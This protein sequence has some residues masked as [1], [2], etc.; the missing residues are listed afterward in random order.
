MENAFKTTLKTKL[1]PQDVFNVRYELYKLSEAQKFELQ[2]KFPS[3]HISHMYRVIGGIETPGV[4]IVMRL[5]EF[6]GRP[7]GNYQDLKIDY[8]HPG[9]LSDEN[10][11]EFYEKIRELPKHQKLFSHSYLNNL[12]TGVIKPVRDT[13]LALLRYLSNH[14]E[15]IPTI[16]QSEYYSRKSL[17]LSSEQKTNVCELMD[18]VR[19]HKINVGMIRQTM[20]AIARGESLIG[21]RL[22]TRLSAALKC[23]PQE[24]LNGTALKRL[25]SSYLYGGKGQQTVSQP[26]DTPKQPER[27]SSFLLRKTN[28]SV[29]NVVLWVREYF[30]CNG[31]APEDLVKQYGRGALIAFIQNA[32]VKNKEDIAQALAIVVSKGFNV[33]LETVLLSTPDAFIGKCG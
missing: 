1:T 8:V 32:P 16:D 17:G 4:S 29:A 10:L 21:D 15:D 6:L 30:A 31:G 12:K 28:A 5:E 14:K 26:V 13:Y 19:R 33:P 24:V 7:I 22:L 25:Q 23:E 2:A 3:F 20:G 9:Q 11:K 18:F 27:A